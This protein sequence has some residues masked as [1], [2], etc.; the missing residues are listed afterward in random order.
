MTGNDTHVGVL[1]DNSESTKMRCIGFYMEVQNMAG[2]T[3]EAR[4][5]RGESMQYSCWRHAY[6]G[7]GVVVAKS[8]GV[9]GL[10]VINGNITRMGGVVGSGYGSGTRTP[11]K[12]WEEE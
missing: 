6:K 1:D 7:R 12:D 2:L 3:F 11:P 10:G 4:L 5:P 8:G 9:I